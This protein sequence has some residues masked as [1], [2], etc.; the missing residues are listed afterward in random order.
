MANKITV[1]LYAGGFSPVQLSQRL[2]KAGLHV[3]SIGVQ[4]VFVE[5]EAGSPGEAETVVRE[6]V[7]I[8]GLEPRS[9]TSYLD[10]AV[11]LVAA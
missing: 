3:R 4:H 9:I 2:A 8:P 5:V 6:A 7:R 10:S 1:E 11:R